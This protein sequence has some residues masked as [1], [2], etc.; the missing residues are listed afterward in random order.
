MAEELTHAEYFQ[1]FNEAFKV[2]EKVKSEENVCLLNR[3][4]AVSSCSSLFPK[5]NL[6]AS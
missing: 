6:G 3:Y 5:L 1:K 2:Y 4:L